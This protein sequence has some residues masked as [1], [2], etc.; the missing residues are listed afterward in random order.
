MSEILALLAAIALVYV[1]LP[2]RMAMATPFVRRRIRP[3]GDIRPPVPWAH[4][5]ERARVELGGLGFEG[6][7]WW[8]SECEGAGDGFSPLR[9]TYLHPV[10]GTWL[11]LMLPPH[12]YM[13]NWLHASYVTRLLDGRTLVSQSFDFHHTLCATE[14]VLG[15]AISEPTFHAQHARHIEWV[16]A[17]GPV[18]LAYASE[19]DPHDVLVAMPE[20]VRQAL[21]AR[22]DLTSV[23][24]RLAT[25]GL[26]FALRLLRAMVDCPQP[27]DTR[28]VAPERMAYLAVQLRE[29]HRR[30]P[31]ARVQWTLFG[32]T[33]LLSVVVGWA[34]WD[35]G[36]A[37]AV[38]LVIALHE[39]GHFIVMRALGYRNL[40]VL[41]LPLVG[42]VAIGTAAR[43][44]AWHRAWMS[45]MGP[46][47]GIVLG[48]SIAIL[49]WNEPTLA[50]DIPNLD[51][52]AILLLV[53]NYLNL[54]P[55][56]PLDGS[57]VV[58]AMLTPRFTRLSVAL[59]A[60]TAIG[61]GAAAWWLG[62][63]A[64]TVLAL[65][66]LPVL[67]GR[68]RLLGVG[69]RLSREL[70]TEPRPTPRLIPIY[71]ELERRFG[72][73]NS[74][75]RLRQGLVL[76]EFLGTEPMRWH[77]AVLIGVL[78]VALAVV[79]FLGLVEVV[80]HKAESDAAQA[81]SEA[82]SAYET[83]LVS[84][85]R[86][87]SLAELVT[88]LNPEG[89]SSRPAS[90]ALL[91]AAAAR[92]GQPL[93]AD[94]ADLY[95][96]TNGLLP[97]SIAPVEAIRPTIVTDPEIPGL[98]PDHLEIWVEDRAELVEI[99]RTAMKGWWWLGD[100]A[101]GQMQVHFQPS[102]DLAVAGLRVVELYPDDIV[103]HVSLRAYLESTW[104]ARRRLA[105]EDAALHAALERLS[106]ASLDEL[107]VL[108]EAPSRFGWVTDWMDRVSGRER[109]STDRPPASPAALDAAEGRLGPLPASI[110]RLYQ[111]GDGIV[112]LG[113]GSLDEI[114]TFR[115][116]RHLYAPG[117]D[118]MLYAFIV[119]CPDCRDTTA[120]PTFTSLTELLGDCLDLTRHPRR[121]DYRPYLPGVLWCGA[122]T[123]V[124][125]WLD[126]KLGR[127]YPD[128]VE[129]LRL[130]IALDAA[131]SLD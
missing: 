111:H 67:R 61:G 114:D 64:L 10:S 7:R 42:G 11:V 12:P 123:P 126:L 63:P 34:F 95:R 40:Q 80:R 97:A 5:F 94:L 48:W 19:P 112:W 76:A 110:R 27:D 128:A 78:Y 113:L 1:L 54:L 58:D 131:G 119:D 49:L 6:P 35:L 86:G 68:W 93:P 69:D 79:P 103:G 72:P 38:L 120:P 66:Q 8:L 65:L 83:E 98:Y 16:A 88:A 99:P 117:V 101:G 15:Q 82:R 115:R 33:S 43:P 77:Q 62:V 23:D 70:A 24:D 4:L 85:A 2:I 116:R 59:G 9:A 31:P 73:T 17:H 71:A 87:F 124:S 14:S 105:D 96:L 106:D 107:L 130:R 92:L 121:D 125:G 118:E 32:L 75:R 29:L 20:R 22:G 37:V 21:I 129:A 46:L 28:P 51:I 55:L 26:R 44:N 36:L 30:S 41:M 50:N 47:P 45:L 39:G 90:D 102:P 56:P 57:H 3:L 25:P 13:A 127:R 52:L 122:G 104:I 84:Q 60:L 91:A 108:I 74:E 81:R 109:V 100:S 89:G 18:D 53:V